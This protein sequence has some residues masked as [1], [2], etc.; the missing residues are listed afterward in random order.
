MRSAAGPG[1]LN[2]KEK[3]KAKIKISQVVLDSLEQEN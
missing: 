3:M 1:K 2:D